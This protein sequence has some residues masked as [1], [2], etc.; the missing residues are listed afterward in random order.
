MH[1][2]LVKWKAESHIKGTKLHDVNMMAFKCLDIWKGSRPLTM[3]VGIEND[4][5]ATQ[6]IKL[7]AMCGG[8]VMISLP[9]NCMLFWTQKM[10][11]I[12]VFW[13]P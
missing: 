10:T 5:P 11:K 8:C 2:L 7:Q 6:S 4:P 13:S 9:S 1:Q 12:R 3:F